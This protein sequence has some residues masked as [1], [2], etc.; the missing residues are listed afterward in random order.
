MRVIVTGGAGFV[1]SW[2]A[3]ELVRLGH[4]VLVLDDLSGGSEKNVPEGAAAKFFDIRN[5]E[6]TLAAFQAFRPELVY[7]LACHPHEGLSQFMPVDIASSVLMGSLSVFSAAVNT[8]VGRVVNFSSM[9]RYGNAGG[10]HAPFSECDPAIPVDVYGAAKYAAERSLNAMGE[11]HGIEH[12]HMVPHNVIGPRQCTSDAYRNVLAI[13][14]TR[15][16]HGL[17]PVIFGDGHQM[18]AL[19]DIRDS[20]PCYI[21]AGLEPMRDFPC[22]CDSSYHDTINGEAINIGGAEPHTINDL[23]RMVLE[24]WGSDLEPIHTGDRP[25]EVKLAY[26]TIRKS[27]DMLGF[28]QTFTVRESIRDFV[29]WAKEQGPQEFRYLKR[30]EVEIIRN[31]PEVWQKELT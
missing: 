30:S 28:R 6:R 3:E 15:L 11:A 25:C 1:G 29:S 16:H 10:H 31:M 17:P 26:V 18:R 24:E 13:W 7:H 9:A 8:D 22:F 27:E 21:R 19:S 2:I 14:C 5:R 23:A 12:V 4:D 20:L